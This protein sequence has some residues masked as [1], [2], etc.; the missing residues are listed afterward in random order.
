MWCTVALPRPNNLA[1]VRK[2]VPVARYQRVT[3]ILSSLETVRRK[4]L[5]LQYN[6][7]CSF[8]HRTLNVCHRIQ[9]CSSHWSSVNIPSTIFFHQSWLLAQVHIVR[10]GLVANT[11]ETKA[12]AL[13]V[14]FRRLIL[15]VYNSC[16]SLFCP[17]D[18]NKW[19]SP[20]INMHS[21]LWS[22]L[23]W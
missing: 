21:T 5:C 17:L 15:R 7:S 11:A 20:Y 23:V 4:W 16:V 22:I 1:K 3:V 6:S 12:A 9:K 2:Y 13:F 19:K 18:W 14:F 8:S 10:R